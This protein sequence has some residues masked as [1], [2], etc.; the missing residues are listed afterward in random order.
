MSSV[1]AGMLDAYTTSAGLSGS[2]ADETVEHKLGRVPQDA[3]IIDR[4]T[5]ARVWRGA[6]VW[7]STQIFLRASASTTII[8]K[9]F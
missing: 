2:G 4:T 6:A 5:S 9:L 7:T 1:K 8:V 3:F